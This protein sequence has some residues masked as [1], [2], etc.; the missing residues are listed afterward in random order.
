MGASGWSAAKA[1]C[2]RVAVAARAGSE[3]QSA[4]RVVSMS[5]M[6]RLRRGA[7]SYTRGGGGMRD[8][9]AAKAV[10]SGP[11]QPRLWMGTHPW[12]ESKTIPVTEDAR[13]ETS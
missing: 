13:E 4:R 8:L 3:R 1:F 12:L 7:K 5:E 2:A 9:G 11:A 6:V 10:A